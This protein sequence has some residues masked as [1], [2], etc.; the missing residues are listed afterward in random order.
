METSSF[1]YLSPKATFSFDRLFIFAAPPNLI[2]YEKT[3]PH[4]A[5]SDYVSVAGI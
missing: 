1:F 4:V 3:M 2:K 5:F